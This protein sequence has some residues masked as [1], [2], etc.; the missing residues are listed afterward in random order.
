MAQ[1]QLNIFLSASI[2]VIGR[3]EKY[4]NTA[5]TIAI[6]DSVLA[7]A[8]IALPKYKLIWGGHPSITPL[9]ANVLQHSDIDIQSSVTLYQSMYFEKFFPLENESVAHII[10]TKDLGDKDLSIN[11]MRERMLKDNE[12]YAGIFIGGMEGVEEEYEIFTRLH[13]ASQVFPIASTGAAA[14]IIYDKYFKNQ[15]PQLYTNLAFS[16]LFKDLL[17]I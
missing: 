2:P 4:F 11:E 5:D 13:P 12:F 17:N 8:S 10:K 16:S 3:N 1:K 15:K 7:L 6:R 14:K 9:I